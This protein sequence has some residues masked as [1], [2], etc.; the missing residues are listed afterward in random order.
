MYVNN[1]SCMS[2]AVENTPVKKRSIKESMG[3][4]VE[5]LNK[6]RSLSGDIRI[7]LDDDCSRDPKSVA[8][9]SDGSCMVDYLNDLE[10]MARNILDNLFLINEII[11]G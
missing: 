6:A 11:Q 4:L 8:P 10:T 5:M 3:N 9:D 1:D 7:S 2:T